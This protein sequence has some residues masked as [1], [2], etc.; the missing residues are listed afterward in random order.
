MIDK[1]QGMYLIGIGYT[2]A[3]GDLKART[4]EWYGN[5]CVSRV[6]EKQQA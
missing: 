1:Q 3:K 5:A 4:L 2:Q 6:L